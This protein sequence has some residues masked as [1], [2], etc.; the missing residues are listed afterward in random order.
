MSARRARGAML[1]ALA[2]AAAVLLG[3]CGSSEIS[4]SLKPGVVSDC[5]RG[6]P[7]ARAAVHE[8]SAKLEGVHRVPLD[9]VLHFLPTA[10]VPGTTLSV[11]DTDTEV[12]TFA[13]LGHFL[14]GQVTDAPPSAEG[15]V[16]IVVVSSNNLHLLA[17]YVGM[18]LP[19]RFSGRV[20]SPHLVVHTPPP[21]TPLAAGAVTAN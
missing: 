19:H 10:T 21:K 17:S 16:A 1:G 11:K 20:A 9:R 15:P 4:L 2:L 5:Y 7:T 13:F 18:G 8:D 12:C 14:P 3:A 6:L